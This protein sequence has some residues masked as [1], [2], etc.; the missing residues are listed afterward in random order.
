MVSVGNSIFF[1]PKEK[2]LHA[3]NAR[4]S[5]F[6]PGGDHICL[7]SVFEQWKETNFSSQWCFENFIQLRS[8]KRA[9]DIKEQLIELCKRVEIDYSQEDLSV[10]DDDIY[11][12]VRKAIASGFFYNTA[13]L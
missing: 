1:R 2:A 6:R 10:V 4:K 12:N 11:T 13:R 7:M 8:M 5:F 9:R 3:D